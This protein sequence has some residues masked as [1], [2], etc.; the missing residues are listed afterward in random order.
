MS[1]NDEKL[2]EENEALAMKLQLANGRSAGRT[3][4]KHGC[5]QKARDLKAALDTLKGEYIKLEKELELSGSAGK[6]AK[7]CTISKKRCKHQEQLA[8][9]QNKLKLKTA[10]TLRKN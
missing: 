8:E 10:R 5:R 4:Q 7:N 1:S 9:M 6:S 2:R 3:L